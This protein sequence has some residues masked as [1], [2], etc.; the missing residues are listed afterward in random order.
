MENGGHIG[1]AN[2]LAVA[3]MEKGKYNVERYRQL[4]VSGLHQ[5][6]SH[7]RTLYIRLYKHLIF[8]VFICTPWC[9]CLRRKY[10]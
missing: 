9:L 2:S 8:Y 3:R 6:C 7:V 1:S 5:D 4:T 10:S